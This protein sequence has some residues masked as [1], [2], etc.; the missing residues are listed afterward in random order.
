[1]QVSAKSC[2]WKAPRPSPGRSTPATPSPRSNRLGCQAGDHRARHCVSK[3]PQREGGSA[4]RSKPLAATGR[5]TGTFDLR[6]L[7]KSP[8]SE[9]PELTSAKIIVS[10]GRALGRTPRTF[11][12]KSSTPL[13][14]KLGA[15]IGA[16]RAAVDAGYVPND[17]QVGQ[18]GKIVAPRGLCS[19]SASRA[20]SSISRA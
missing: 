14:D 13:A 7:R 18:T 12:A 11:E 5:C 3:R 17:Y 15:A 4:A 10:G 9:R 20:R 8:R 19:L 16:S 6:Q 1:M 2:R